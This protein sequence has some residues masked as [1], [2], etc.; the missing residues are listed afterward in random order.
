MSID[1]S[2][3]LR[4]RRRAIG[5]GL[6]VLAA[7]G[8]LA[9]VGGLSTATAATRPI[10]AAQTSTVQLVQAYLTALAPAGSKFLKVEAALKTLGPSATRAQVL[11]A[12]APLGPVLVPIEALLAAPPPTTLEA[13]GQ[14][15][16]LGYEAKYRTTGRGCSSRRWRQAVPERLPSR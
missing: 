11:A 8:I 15:Q 3:L 9:P 4:D 7:L 5:L 12:V 2:V 16:S 14:P 1:S 6:G 13:L 10:A